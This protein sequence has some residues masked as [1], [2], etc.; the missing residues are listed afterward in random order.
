MKRILVTSAAVLLMALS[1]GESHACGWSGCDAGCKSGYVA[2]TKQWKPRASN[3]PGKCVK[4]WCCPDQMP[5]DDGFMCRA[6]C[7]TKGSAY[8]GYFQCMDKCLGRK[9]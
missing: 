7:G 2:I 5:R 8:G 9:R 6:K 3:R 1:V 4:T